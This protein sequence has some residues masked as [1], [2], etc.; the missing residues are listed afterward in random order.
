MKRFLTT[1]IIIM[2]LCGMVMADQFGNVGHSVQVEDEVGAKVTTVTSVEIYAPSTTTNA[3]IYKRRNKQDLITIPMT[4]SSTNTTLSDGGFTWFGPSDYAFSIT[5]GTNIVNSSGHRNRSASEGII[6]LPSYITAISSTTYADGATITMGTSGDWVFEAGTTNDLLRFTPA[7]DGAVFRVGDND[8][9]TNADFRVHVGTDLGLLIDEG[10]PSF[11]W[12]GGAANINASSNFNTNIN[13]GTSTGAISIGNS[14]AGIITI[15]STT[16]MTVNSDAAMSLTTSD[17]SANITVDATAGSIIIDGGE[18][19]ADAVTITATGA[20]GGIDIT[21]LADIDITTTGAAGEDISLT[22]TGGSIN[23]SATEAIADATTIESTAGG[24]DITTAATFDIDITATGGRVIVTGNEAVDDAVTL[25]ATGA[26]GGIDITSLGDI[27]I[28]T[29][30]AAGEDIAIT[31]TGGSITISATEAVADAL[32]ISTTAAGG[33]LNL[34]S[35]LGRIEIEAEEDV[36]NAIFII[37]DGDTAST[38]KLLNDT[39]T[40]ATDAAASIQVTSDVGGIELLSS[41]AA[42]NQIRLNAAG[43]VAGNAVV[44]E[45]TD[46]GIQLNADGGTNGDITIDAADV[47]SLVAGDAAGIVTTVA[48][49]EHKRIYYPIGAGIVAATEVIVGGGTGLVCVGLEAG[50]AEIG[51]TEGFAS[52]GDAADFMRFMIALPDDFVDTGT[53]AD[54]VIRFDI[55]EQAAEEMNWDFRLF[56]YDGNANTTAILTDTIVAANDGTRAMK[57]LVTNSTGIGNEADLDSG[58]HLIVELTS[59]ADTDD[60]DLYGIEITYRVGLQPNN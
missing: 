47:I 53:Q 6:I 51:T 18:A 59:S 1:F 54:Y 38:M 10:V 35:V 29:T 42:A 8:A 9:A 43:T 5:D 32:T 49:F 28:T 4:T 20:A 31:N 16:T 36:A 52:L 11:T 55:D 40:S 23:L 57:G 44:L 39:G 26:A 21:S 46:G 30:G 7:T 14:A 37:A 60:G 34:D 12:N 50:A 27:D 33:D 25:T 22:N 2:F 24:M 41:L 15:D 48:T 56:E 58:D 45:T 19:V 3:V 17:A 13:T